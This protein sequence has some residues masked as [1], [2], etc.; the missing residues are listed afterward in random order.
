MSIHEGVYAWEYD[1]ED[2]PYPELRAVLAPEYSRL[3]PEDLEAVFEAVG[4]SAEDMEFSLK[5]A[6]RDVGR[7]V[8][9]AAPTI[10][11]VAGTVLG[12]AFGGPAGAALGGMLGRAA[13]GALGGTGRRAPARPG[14]PP[15]MGGSPAASQLL[16][17][18]Q[19]PELLQGL[20][21][22]ALGPAARG[23]VPVGRTPV[24]AGAFANLVGAL[25]NQAQAE[26]HA[27]APEDDEAVPEYLLDASG[28]PA[29][30]AAIPEQRAARLLELLDEA[31]READD[32]GWA[33]ADLDDVFD[34]IELAELTYERAG[35]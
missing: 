30:D 34:D 33:E 15:G 28:A 3:P 2:D 32:E 16:Q 17:V 1:P 21:S 24:P 18:L 20:L 27:A 23:R 8:K 35:R 25:A 31:A 5:K 26:Y 6:F 19:R 22:M 4:L 10:L 7:F 14:A 12:T 11:P 13:G 29:V 9:S